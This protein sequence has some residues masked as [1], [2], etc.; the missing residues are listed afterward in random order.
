M[1]ATDVPSSQDLAEGF[2][3]FLFNLTA[4]F[5]ALQLNDITNQDHDQDPVPS[6]FLVSDHKAYKALCTSKPNKSSGPDR[7]PTWV[8][9]EF[10]FELA[11]MVSD[12]YNCSFREGC[13]PDLV[14]VS[15]VTPVPKVTPPKKL[16]EDLRPITLTTPLTKILDFTVEYLLQQVADKL[17]IKQFSISGKSTTH[18]LVYLLHCILETLDKGN[19]YARV[20]FAD[21]FKRFD[22]VD[23]NALLNEY[24]FLK[25][26]T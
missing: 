19:M 13:F 21:F 17:D 11:P 4:H 26:M 25:F 23:H 14:K 15:L 3:R 10:A 20:F 16:E 7:I 2:N 6:E 1:I 12:I 18:A 22:L 9:K 24:I 8:W 5:N